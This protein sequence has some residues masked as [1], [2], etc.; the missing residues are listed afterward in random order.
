MKKC[1]KLVL[2]AGHNKRAIGKYYETVRYIKAKDVNEIFDIARRIRGVKKD[3]PIIECKPISY[4]DYKKGL[5]R[6]RRDY[7]RYYKIKMPKE[8]YYLDK[9]EDEVKYAIN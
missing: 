6:A 4:E 5:I 7:F 3:F 2:R 9:S 8:W 1:Y